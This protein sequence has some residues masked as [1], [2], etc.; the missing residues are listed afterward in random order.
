MNLVNETEIYKAIKSAIIQQK[1]RPNTQLVE[2]VLAESFGVSRTPV[3]NA[4]RRLAFEKLVTI[5]PH[6]GTFV[7]APSVED[8]KEVFEMRRLLETAA[9]RQ[10]C[11]YFTEGQFRELKQLLDD[12]HRA[13]EEGDF[14]AALQI[15]G[16]FH[17]KIAELTRNSYLYRYLEE[18]VSLTYVIIAFYG[19]RH[20]T[21]CSSHEH[22]QILEAMKK[23]DVEI[24]VDL[25]SDHLTKIE[26]SLD[27]TENIAASMSLTD[28]FSIKSHSSV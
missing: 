20:L 4:L 28:I 22:D 8:A 23:R 24:A 14:F 16:D 18:L 9:I 13:H 3:R 15:S 10:G 12:E 5:I 17:L 6:K 11:S 26:M 7:S 1:V 27:F 21:S 25:I 19:Y 2:E